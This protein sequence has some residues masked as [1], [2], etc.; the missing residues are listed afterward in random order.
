MPSSSKRVFDDMRVE[1]IEFYVTDAAAAADR[2]FSG[3]GFSQHPVPYL[4][5]EARSLG[6]ASGRIR[7]VLTEALSVRHPAAA[8][9]ERHG[10]GVADIALGVR[11]A[12]AAFAEATRRGARAVAPPTAHGDVVTA[13]IAGFGDVVH[14]FVQ[15]AGNRERLEP[16]RTGLAGVLLEVDHFA[17]VV[18]PG[19]I[20]DTVEFYRRVLDFDLVFTEHVV[21]GA[22]AMTTKVV[23]SGSGAVTLTL[24][25]PDPTREAGHVA[26]FL[27]D[28]GGA[29]VQHVAFAVDDIVTA[30]DA[31]ASRGVEFL[32]T[33]ATYYQL[34]PE[35]LEL[36]RHSVE[37]LRRLNI[38]VDEDHDGQL[39]QIFARSTHPRDTFFLEL[40]E[41]LGAR[42]FGS[43]N[44]AA[45]YRAVELQRHAGEAGEAA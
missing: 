28:H 29:G 41:R 7:M 44:I 27:R 32:P 25:E 43:G 20:D 42:T 12:A 36:H 31:I 17:V 6:L 14:T 16:V 5:K 1:H 38:L 34:L 10:D 4:Q 30:I 15:R 9:V 45:L 8:Y 11:D 3:Y 13:R 37:E 24:V 39:F 22:Q 33:P 18:E 26:D 21:V 19:R 23:Q 35:R 40:I 2:L